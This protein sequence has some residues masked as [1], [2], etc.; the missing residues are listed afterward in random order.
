[1]TAKELYKQIWD[2]MFNNEDI[3]ISDITKY[4][5]S[6]QNQQSVARTKPPILTQGMCAVSA[7]QTASDGLEEENGFVCDGI[8]LFQEV[9]SDSRYT[10]P[11]SY[12]PWHRYT[13]GPTW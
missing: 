12:N 13:I 5:E 11:D 2:D 3:T 6:N 10:Y 7:F 9:S 4:Q 8:H 1:M